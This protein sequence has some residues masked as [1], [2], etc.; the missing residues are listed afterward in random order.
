[1]AVELL[2]R[3]EQLLAEDALGVVG[4]LGDGLVPD[5]AFEAPVV[6]VDVV[7]GKDCLMGKRDE[8]LKS[9]EVFLCPYPA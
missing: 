1:M 5:L 7:R 2:S 9:P 8:V 6:R 4:L 3:R